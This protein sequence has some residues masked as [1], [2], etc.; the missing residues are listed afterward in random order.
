MPTGYEVQVFAKPTG[1]PT[2]THVL[3]FSSMTTVKALVLH[4]DGYL[5]RV[6]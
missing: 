2:A 1:T 5:G 6:R 3:T 4:A